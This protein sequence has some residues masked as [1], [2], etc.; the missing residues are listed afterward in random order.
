MVLMSQSVILYLLKYDMIVL[1]YWYSGQKFKGQEKMNKK[2]N[3][4]L[5]IVSCLKMHELV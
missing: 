2:N 5:N 3:K 4:I 1:C